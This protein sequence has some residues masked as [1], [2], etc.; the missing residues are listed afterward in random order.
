MTTT[1]TQKK[2]GPIRLMNG[3]TVANM[4]TYYF[5]TVASLLLFTFLPQFQPFLL[6]EVLNIPES[7][8]G[9]LSGNL[10]FFAEIIILVS[11]GGWGTLSDKVGRKLVFSVGFLLM[12]LALL[13]YPNV[14]SVVTLF[15][16]RG[17]FALGSSAVTTMISTVIADY[18]MDEDRGKA[19]GLQGVGNGIG[20]L[21]TVFVVLQ[22]PKIF[23]NDGMS[24]LDAGRLTYWALAGIAVISVVLLMIGLQNRTKTQQEQKKSILE[25]SKE[26]F[27]AAK[28][29]G[30]AL[31]YMAAFISR[32]DLAIVGTF[33][34]LWVVT[35]GTTQKGLSTADALANAGM[36]IGISQTMALISAPIFGIFAD[37]MNRA[38]AV[39]LAVAM[40]S[41]GYGSTLFVSDPTSPAIFIVAALIGIGEIS[42]VIASGVLIAQQAPR[43]IRGSVIGIFSLCGTFGIMAATG[44]GGQLF[45]NWLP[46]GPFVLFS[47][48]GWVVVIIGLIIRKKIVPRN[49]KADITTG[50]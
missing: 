37:R 50:H 10:Q 46:Q 40:A 34:T 9:V 48:L 7:Q 2:F 43:D 39:I 45:D 3:V 24:A 5:A 25:I 49:E 32:G 12:G 31:A 8:Q 11:I 30:V 27:A 18:A 17:L 28:D 20:A 15:I 16:F 38:N 4:F 33:F 44:I 13:Y 23:I 26:G 42:G 6:T 35:Y 41:I 19:S 14:A 47:A 1:T 29:P 36:I 22:L 21:L